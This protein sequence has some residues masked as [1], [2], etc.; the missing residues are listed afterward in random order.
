MYNEISALEDFIGE[1]GRSCAM[2]LLPTN[3]NNTNIL[4]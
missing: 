2:M 4:T 1:R 3:D